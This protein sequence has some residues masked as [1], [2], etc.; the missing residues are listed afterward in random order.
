MAKL[1]EYNGY[2]CESE[3]EYAFI[4]FL[5]AISTFIKS[6]QENVSL[7]EP[8]EWN[9]AYLSNSVLLKNITRYSGNRYS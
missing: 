4:G 1:K 6:S 2:Y 5:E 8:H 3:Y 9:L 7:A